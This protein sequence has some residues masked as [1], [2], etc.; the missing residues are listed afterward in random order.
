MAHLAI[1]LRPVLL[2]DKRMLSFYI[3]VDVISGF[4]LNKHIAILYLALI[5][6]RKD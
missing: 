6:I 1:T 4:Q 3:P 2:L 5:V